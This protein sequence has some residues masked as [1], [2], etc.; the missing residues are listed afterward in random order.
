MPLTLLFLRKDTTLLGVQKTE[1]AM[2]DDGSVN[3]NE[4]Y[5]AV[6]KRV[7]NLDTAPETL[8]EEA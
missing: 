8:M 7:E 5:K 1:A 4:G 3:G 2:A 6:T